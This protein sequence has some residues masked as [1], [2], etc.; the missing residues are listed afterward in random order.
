[1]VQKSAL[2]VLVL[3]LHACGSNFEPEEAQAE[4]NRIR[5]GQQQCFGTATF[6]E[7]VACFEECGHECSIVHGPTC[8]FTC[9]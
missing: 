2:L 3:L 4:C 8:G 7:C 1:M 6:D 9:D 5:A